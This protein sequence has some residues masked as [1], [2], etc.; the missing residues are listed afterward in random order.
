MLLHRLLPL[1]ALPLMSSA[2]SEKRSKDIDSNRLPNH[3][4]TAPLS[5]DNT[6]DQWFLHGSSSS[7]K[8]YVVVNPAVPNRYGYLWHKQPIKTRDFEI[9]VEFQ[10][11]GEPSPSAK[12]QGLAMW[13]TS[14]NF[15]DQFKMVTAD[16]GTDG[17]DKWPKHLSSFGFNAFGCPSRFDGVGVFLTTHDANK[18][19]NPVVTTLVGT[20][21][22]RPVAL[23]RDYPSQ[24]STP[25]NFRNTKYPMVLKIRVQQNRVT[26]HSFNKESE[27]SV[28][29]LVSDLK[30]VNIK[31]EG[32]IGFSS[33]TGEVAE[34]AKPDMVTV[35]AVIVTNLDPMSV[36]ELMEKGQND[37]FTDEAVVK[38]LLTSDF[39]NLDHRGQTQMLKRITRIL[40]NHIA[41]ALKTDRKSFSDLVSLQQRITGIED[42]VRTIRQEVKLAFGK[43][44]DPSLSSSTR[45]EIHG[46]KSILTKDSASQKSRLQH[47]HEKV[48]HATDSFSNEAAF[49]E[50][51]EM[52]RTATETLEEAI[53]ASHSWTWWLFVAMLGAVAALGLSLWRKMKSYEKRHFL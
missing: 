31:Q 10:F 24:Q 6:L 38:E 2:D 7:L 44:A 51:L 11:T 22:G 14:R 20:E 37:E 17:P 32:Y 3:S 50:N 47:L 29:K 8:D 12:D 26:V 4:F 40:H 36:G 9:I 15:T 35:Q 49:K 53:L 46:L 45:A 48:K 41:F 5:F 28:W 25:L 33:Y 18:N 21:G 19:P 1:L 34:G 27:N 16:I 13:F 43:N 39:S 23:G 52:V 42:D 30:D